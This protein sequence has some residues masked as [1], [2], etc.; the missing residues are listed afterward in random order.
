MPRIPSWVDWS[1]IS[2]PDTMK[3]FRD[4][5]GFAACGCFRDH[6]SEVPSWRPPAS[7]LTD[8]PHEVSC[9]R[10]LATYALHKVA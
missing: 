9:G 4:K 2:N 3:H 7:A 8:D 6:M 10:C 5:D 1:K